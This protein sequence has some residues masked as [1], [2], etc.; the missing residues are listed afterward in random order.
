M[1]SWIEKMSSERTMKDWVADIGTGIVCAAISEFIFDTAISVA[2]D[3]VKDNS[4]GVNVSGTC[5]GIVIGAVLGSAVAG[6]I[7]NYFNECE[8]KAEAEAKVFSII[9]IGFGVIATSVIATSVIATSVIATSD[10]TALV[11]SAVFGVGVI[12]AGVYFAKHIFDA[13]DNFVIAG[14]RFFDNSYFSDYIIDRAN[15][16]IDYLT[17]EIFNVGEG[18]FDSYFDISN[19]QVD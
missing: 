15:N 7:I 13:I 18:F 9:F 19:N 8:A 3:F 4:F 16:V 11:S 14:E 12:A 6:V 5:S 2:H 10:N 1:P 17:E